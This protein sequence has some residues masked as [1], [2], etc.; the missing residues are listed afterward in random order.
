MHKLEKLL[1]RNL[2]CSRTEARRILANN[3]CTLPDPVPDE[4]LPIRGSLAGNPIELHD[5][6]HLMLHKPAGCVTALSD[7]THPCA[8]AYVRDA[9]LGVELR[10][11]GRLDLDT[12]GL[13]LWTTDGD[14]LHR[15][16]RP[17][18]AVRRGYHAALARPFRERPQD[19]VLRDGHLPR[20]LELRAMA[21]AEAHPGLIQPEGTLAL[22]SIAIA[23][24]AY[25]EVRRIFAALDSHVLAL[26]RVSFGA[27]TLPVDLAAGRWRQID[28]ADVAEPRVT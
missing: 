22:A 4:A 21:P 8:A 28:P 16:T 10:A 18:E 3:P 1:A 23:G 2:G 19:L 7:P 27:L 11:V 14:W 9:P 6:F 20:I 26:C 13:L 17:R 5:S 15:L 25:H 24:G 12:T